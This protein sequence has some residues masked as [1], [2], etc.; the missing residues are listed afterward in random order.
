MARVNE[1][2]TMYEFQDILGSDELLHAIL[3][4]FSTDDMVDCLTSIA[5][6]YDIEEYIIEVDE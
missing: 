3:C 4:Y 2:E 6:D 5:C 1:F